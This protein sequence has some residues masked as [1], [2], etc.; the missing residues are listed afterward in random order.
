MMLNHVVARVAL[1]L[2]FSSLFTNA[3][4]PSYDMTKEA[5]S[6]TDSKTFDFNPTGRIVGGSSVSEKIP[7]MASLNNPSVG[8]NGGH[9][10]GGSLINRE[11]VITAA[12]CIYEY[13][14]AAYTHSVHIGMSI[15]TER[16]F[17]H[18]SAISKIVVHPEFDADYLVNDIALVRLKNSAPEGLVVVPLNKDKSEPEDI[19]P[20][21]YLGWGLLGENF[22]YIP[23]QLKSVS[24]E[25]LSEDRCQSVYGRKLIN[26]KN[27]CTYT[28]GKDSCQGDS[29]GPLIQPGEDG[30]INSGV[31]VGIISFGEGCA[32]AG[33][34]GVNTRISS[35]LDWIYATMSDTS[36]IDDNSES[37]KS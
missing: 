18:T 13:G 21:W 28:P 22:S 7:F 27:I 9:Y 6:G 11:W 4:S 23:N 30:G 32:R 20:L 31:L 17:L 36:A 34:P 2:Q 5:V 19:T 16:D 14:K 35:F 8:V 15:Q 29:G 12:H 3:A 33:Y 37:T 26:D 25:S 10:C 1:S 24:V